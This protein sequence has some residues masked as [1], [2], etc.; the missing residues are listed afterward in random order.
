MMAF[1]LLRSR[2]APAPAAG[3]CCPLCVEAPLLRDEVICHG[4]R[5]EAFR[6]GVGRQ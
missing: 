6:L 4:C 2:P 3:S 1:T 5:T